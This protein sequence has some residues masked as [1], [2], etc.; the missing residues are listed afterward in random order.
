MAEHLQEGTE[1][2]PDNARPDATGKVPPREKRCPNFFDPNLSGHFRSTLDG[3]LLECNDSFVRM[4]GYA[5]QREVL[6]HNAWD[7][8]LKRDDRDAAISRL[9]EQKV[10]RNE[11]VCLRR[12]DGSL[13]WILANRALDETEHPPVIEGTVMDITAPKRAEA[14]IR[15]L[16]RI[17]KTL[18]CIRNIDT[19]MDSLIIEAVKLTE[20]EYG[21]SGIRTPQGMVCHKYLRD[22]EFI[23]F[24]YCWPPGIG[25]AGWILVHKVPYVT[26]DAQQDTV[27]IP[28]FRERFGVKSAISTPLLDFRGETIGFLEVNNKRDAS[29]FTQADMEKME[30]TCQVA[31]VALQ[32]ALAYQKIQRN[33]QEL[34]QLSTRLLQLQDEERR[35]L[36]RELHDSTGQILATLALRIGAANR[37]LRGDNQ[38]ARDI[39]IECSALARQCSDDLRTLSYLLHPPS[40]DEEGLVSALHWYVQGFTKRSGIPVDLNVPTDG[41]RLPR[42]VEAALFR[43]VQEGLTNVHLHSKSPK[44]W[45]KIDL[46]PVEVILEVRD[47]GCGIPPEVLKRI[48]S[49]VSHVGI[50]IA[51]MRE[52]IRQLGGRLEIDSGSWGTKA[53]AVLPV[54]GGSGS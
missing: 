30:A 11:E 52:R 45:V 46:S 54:S 38:Q 24:E 7:L 21:W 12:K 10:T 16:F 28:E 14:D 53:R 41:A 1:V 40:L 44:A 23:P 27:I 3:R 33:E 26:N 31:S 25:W 15:A 39:L 43:V 4:L 22:G 5:S 37:S 51:G 8:Y 48:P 18:N 19:L 34:R 47:E 49:G 2:D 17:S 6:R 50:G 13:M 29:G 35:R 42:E 32:N 9:L 20:A 36:A